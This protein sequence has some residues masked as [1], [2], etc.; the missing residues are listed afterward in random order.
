MVE[1]FTYSQKVKGHHIMTELVIGHQHGHLFHLIVSNSIIPYSFINPSPKPH[2]HYFYFRLFL[3]LFLHKSPLGEGELIRFFSLTPKLNSPLNKITATTIK[4]KKGKSSYTWMSDNVSSTLLPLT[5]QKQVS[6]WNVEGY[7]S[8]Y[9]STLLKMI[10]K[11]DC[12]SA[13]LAVPHGTAQSWGPQWRQALE[14]EPPV[15]ISWTRLTQ[16]FMF[17]LNHLPHSTL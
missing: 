10:L 2:I 11:D 1:N 4:R 9:L 8:Q 14:R 16:S 6:Q 5:V 13:S 3:F 7:F 12:C 15:S 17:L